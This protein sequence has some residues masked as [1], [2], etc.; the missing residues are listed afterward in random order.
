MNIVSIDG[1]SNML[2]NH[3]YGFDGDGNE[4]GLLRR[5]AYNPNIEYAPLDDPSFSNAR[6]I[7]AVSEDPTINIDIYEF[8]WNVLQRILPSNISTTKSGDNLYMSSGGLYDVV[9]GDLFNMVIELYGCDSEDA[10]DLDTRV[11]GMLI[12]FHKLL[13]TN[14]LQLRGFKTKSNL[15]IS[16]EF[17]VNRDHSQA[18]GFQLFTIGL[19]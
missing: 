17:K 9:D 1:I 19:F 10:A 14:P 12:T 5:I 11:R 3:A 7:E 13:L 18:E 15:V 8:N 6:L 16:L 4:L 2:G